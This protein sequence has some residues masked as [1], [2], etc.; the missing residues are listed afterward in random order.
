[1]QDNVGRV[2]IALRERVSPAARRALDAAA[3]D[4]TD[5]LDGQ[6]VF[7]VYPSAA[8]RTAAASL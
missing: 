3:G 1:M 4:L 5:W 7:S 8:M 6:R 2:H